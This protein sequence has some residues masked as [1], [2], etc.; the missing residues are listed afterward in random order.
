MNTSKLTKTGYEL[1]SVHIVQTPISY[2]E[3]R[4]ECDPTI[5]LCGRRVKPIIVS[6]MGAVTNE[7]NYKVWLDNGLICVVPRTVDIY[8][9]LEISTET[10]ASFSLNEAED[11]LMNVPD[12]TLSEGGAVE[13]ISTRYVCID[14]AHGTMSRLYDICRQLK[15]K[16][17]DKMVIMTG[18]VATPEAYAFYADAGIDYMRATI[19][20]GSR[21]VVGGTEITMADGSKI[22]IEEIDRGDFVKTSMGNKRVVN[23]FIKDTLDTIKINGVECTPDHRF[24]VVNK[25]DITENMSDDEIMA[26]GVYKEA[27]EL[28]KEW[29]LVGE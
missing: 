22:P 28:T 12:Y 2:I 27:R 21:C 19:G 1:E 14:I 9:R 4:A 17:G 3:H 13:E 5:E 18:N 16:Y 25:S 26:K 10:F 20:T 8:K 24:F 11:V 23:T 29:V 6:P 7:N 15:N